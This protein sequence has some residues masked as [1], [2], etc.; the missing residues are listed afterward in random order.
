[1]KTNFK[2]LLVIEGTM[3]TLIVTLT[4][5]IY[6]IC[7]SIDALVFI[8]IILFS[9]SYLYKELLLLPLDL[10]IGK[11]ERIVKY[12][13][14]V[15]KVKFDF[16]KNKYSSIFVFS[17]MQYKLPCSLYLILPYSFD[18]LSINNIEFPESYDEVKIVYYRFSK[19]LCYFE[20]I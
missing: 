7:G 13:Y 9:T 17:Y 6:A 18:N 1:M 4:I 19:L 16:F 15:D 11:K 5:L 10:L 8:I 12:N 14:Y 3:V 2:K 20:V